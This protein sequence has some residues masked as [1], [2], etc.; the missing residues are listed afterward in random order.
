M[1]RMRF[2]LSGCPVLVRCPIKTVSRTRP[3]LQEAASSTDECGIDV[4]LRGNDNIPIFVAG[5]KIVAETLNAPDI[6][7]VQ[8]EIVERFGASLTSIEVMERC[9]PL[10]FSMVPL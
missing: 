10:R 5:H 8:R 9:A 1:A 6:G 3:V 7:G 4:L 2:G